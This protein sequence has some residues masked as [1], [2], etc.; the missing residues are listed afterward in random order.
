MYLRHGSILLHRHGSIL[1]HRHIVTNTH[2]KMD[3]KDLKKGKL[4]NMELEIL[5]RQYLVRNYIVGLIDD[6]TTL[7]DELYGSKKDINE[8]LV[9]IAQYTFR[10]FRNIETEEHMTF[11]IRTGDR[12]NIKGGMETQE[13][14][15]MFILVLTEEVIYVL[16][17]YMTREEAINLLMSV[18]Q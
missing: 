1:L 4:L 9:R 14:K 13:G 5:I 10:F 6:N 7:F 2:V 17:D 16:E 3:N 15:S 8:L 18:K 12:H 11:N